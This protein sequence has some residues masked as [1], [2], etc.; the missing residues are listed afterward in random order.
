MSTIESTHDIDRSKEKPMPIDRSGNDRTKRWKHIV[1]RQSKYS[2]NSSEQ[3]VREDHA[4]PAVTVE[5]RVP[6][7]P[8]LG[9][10]KQ[11]YLSPM[12]RDKNGRTVASSEQTRRGCG[13]YTLDP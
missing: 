9:K 4:L 12:L 13:E 10:A 6:G 1:Q 11:R 2:S 5:T 8:L 7:R 3:P